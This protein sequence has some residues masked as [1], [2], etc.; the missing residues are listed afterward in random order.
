MLLLTQT[1]SCQHPESGAHPLVFFLG[2]RISGSGSRH[3]GESYGYG[4]ALSHQGTA[5]FGL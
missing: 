3:V 1:A 5:G 4:S 2:L